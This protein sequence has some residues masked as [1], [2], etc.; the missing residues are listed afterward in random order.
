MLEILIPI[1]QNLLLERSHFFKT[2]NDVN[3]LCFVNQFCHMSISDITQSC[4]T[5]VLTLE[6]LVS[7]VMRLVE[8]QALFTF[9]VTV[10]G[11]VR[12]FLQ[13]EC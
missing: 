8:V 4:T 5:N 6:N 11:S 10:I 7:D 9:H 2:T 3:S 12:W 1:V 13:Q